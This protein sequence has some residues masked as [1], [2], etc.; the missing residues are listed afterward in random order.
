MAIKILAI[1]ITLKRIIPGIRKLENGECFK[2]SAVTP[3]NFPDGATMNKA[4]ATSALIPT[5]NNRTMEI[6]RS[7]FAALVFIQY[8]KL[9]IYH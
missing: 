4:P 5:K 1:P 9:N 3:N 2:S 7:R 6:I 8:S